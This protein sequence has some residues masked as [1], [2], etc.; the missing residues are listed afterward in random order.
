MSNRTDLAKRAG[1]MVRV[2][3]PVLGLALLAGCGNG[4]DRNKRPTPTVGYVVVQPTAVPMETSLG[5]R[6]VAF[7]TSDVRP[8]VS[9][10]IRTR[11]FQEGGTVRQGQPLFQIDPS[12]YRAAVS[13][14]SANLQ[15]AQ[16]NAVA[17]TI[18]AERFRPLAEME[19][20][21][22]QQYTDALAQSRQAKASVAQTGAALE[23]ARI[24]LRY[25][26]VPA[27][28]SGRIGRSL[29]TTG[30]LVNA[31]QADALAV[32]QQVDPIYVDM[33]QSS[34]ELLA[35]KRALASGGV[36]AGSTSVRLK[37]E[38]GSDYPF[39]GT[40][41]FSEMMVNEATGTITLRARFPNPHGLLLP[42]MFVQARFDQAVNPAAYLVPQG[43]VMRD[44]SG[45]AF[46]Y[47]AGADNKAAR[48]VITADRAV[49]P[50]WV[51]TA[52]LKPGDRIIT[53]GLANLKHGMAIKPVPQSAPQRVVPPKNGA[54]G[55]RP[56]RG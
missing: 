15:A 54:G 42:G 46:V 11:L 14:A 43:A 16:A 53:Q 55:G 18:K 13:Q 27:P 6:T 10:V 19:A 23:T 29:F 1:M 3:G 32:I 36:A 20:I 56:D 47:I 30:A 17:A 35:L 31:N 33:Q 9:G 45:D 37:L 8:Q 51:V 50:N 48:R 39:A 52:G 2:L 34:A 24:N 4:E 21:S 38:D 22:R 49:G 12:L 5:G 26:T 44:I 28:I 40:V 41:Q 25:T 7:A